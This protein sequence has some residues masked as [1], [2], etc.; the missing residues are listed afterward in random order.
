MSAVGLTLLVL[1][2]GTYALKA[3]GPLVLGSRSLP[4]SAVPGGAVNGVAVPFP[5][6]SIVP[7][8]EGLWVLTIIR[9]GHPT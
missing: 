9:L 5:L 7:S 2:L 4:A 6:S 3:A 8:D 1:A